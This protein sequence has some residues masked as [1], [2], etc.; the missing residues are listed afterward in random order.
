MSSSFSQLLRNSKLSKF[1]PKLSQVY[2]TY[3]EYQKLGD[4]GVK[5]NLPNYLRTN[6]VTINEI[7]TIE[8]QTPYNS[9]ETLI[10]FKRKWK[11]NFLISKTVEPLKSNDIY[12][13]NFINISKLSLKDFK[14][15][16]KK[17]EKKKYD[18]NQLLINSTY[19]SN[20]WL[21]FL[22]LTFIKKSSNSIIK[23]LN[24][25]HNNP[26][27]NFKVQ[28]RTLNKD[29]NGIF[30]IGISGLVCSLH[31]GKAQRLIQVNRKKLDNFYLEKVDFDDQGRPNIRV[32]HSPILSYQN[33]FNL[34]DNYPGK[35]SLFFD[36]AT[37]RVKDNEKTQE[38]IL[39]RLRSLLK[40]SGDS[41]TSNSDV[42]PSSKPSFQLVY[43]E[44]F[45]SNTKEEGGE[46]NNK[47]L[48]EILSENKESTTNNSIKEEGD[49]KN[50]N[51]LFEVL[52]E[53]EGG[54]KNGKNLFEVLSENK[55]STK[56]MKFNE[57][58]QVTK[59]LTGD[60][61]SD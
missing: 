3:G 7:D 57:E 11:E 40:T 44:M 38:E 19:N 12:Q 4:Y 8:H 43:E 25:S 59:D 34:F 2:K 13:R 54:E 23:G 29:S 17:I 30:A 9:A 42:G 36:S 6:V 52:S 22:G 18:W 46:K 32:S 27:I 35:N 47:N 49:E 14:K 26:G 60:K 53:N 48:F 50:G 61:N 51:N 28:G 20:N 24:Y 33:D 45:S 58:N 1:D 56:N 15:L 10:R 31:F 5:R 21:E 41:T 37:N 39:T 16:L 55:E